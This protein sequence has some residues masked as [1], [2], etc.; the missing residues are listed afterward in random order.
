M[1]SISYN[2][3]DYHGTGSEIFEHFQ[4]ARDDLALTEAERDTML[5][6]LHEVAEASDA[7]E[8]DDAITKI[9]EF[10]NNRPY[11]PGF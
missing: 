5:S 3:I 8:L 11:P 9:K 7:D 6:L 2:E 1:K 10:T 4:N